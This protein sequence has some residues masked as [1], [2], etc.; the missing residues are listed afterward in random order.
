MCDEASSDDVLQWLVVASP[1]TLKEWLDH[2]DTGAS[3]APPR[4]NWLGL[5]QVTHGAAQRSLDLDGALLAV[6]LYRKWGQDSGDHEDALYRTMRL[7]GYLINRLGSRPGH[8]VLDL[9]E[10]IEWFRKRLP[11]IS[12]EQAP[13]R[14]TDLRQM[15]IEDIRTLRAV[16]NRLG[17]FDDIPLEEYPDVGTWRTIRSKLP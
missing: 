17:T 14:P 4:F 16:K 8:P 1:A 9:F 10:L 15:N 12:A 2:V 5:A 13:Q 6:R 7:R 11:S 3:A